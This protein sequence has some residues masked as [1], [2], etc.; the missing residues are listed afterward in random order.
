MK[1]VF[2]KDV[3]GLGK[4]DEIKEVSDGY[5]RNFLFPRGLVK[6][7]NNAVIS[8]LKVKTASEEKHLEVVREKAR[9]LTKST[10]EKPLIFNLKA[11]KH[12][13]VFGSITIE[14][15]E[16]KLRKD[17]AAKIGDEDFKIKAEHNL[18]TLGSH[19]IELDFGRGISGKI[20]VFIEK[21]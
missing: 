18:K 1:V 12:N 21:V 6:A 19:E 4:K 10:A 3:K 5:A 14:E 9:E 8:E 2:L 11:G 20:K 15:I 7:A 16:K 13:E 17:Y